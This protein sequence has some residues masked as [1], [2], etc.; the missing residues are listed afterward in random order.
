MYFSD[1]FHQQNS[2]STTEIPSET[3]IALLRIMASDKYEKIWLIKGQ[4]KKIF[5][6]LTSQGCNIPG[7]N[8][9]EKI[10][11]LCQKWR[12][13]KKLALKHHHNK[14]RRK[15]TPRPIH[16]NL[17][18]HIITKELKEKGENCDTDAN[19]EFVGNNSG[20]QDQKQLDHDYVG[21][22]EEPTNPPQV[23]KSSHSTNEES[24]PPLLVAQDENSVV[25]D[26]VDSNDEHFI[27]PEIV[28]IES[29]MESSGS[30]TKDVFQP[31][32]LKSDDR[33]E[34]VCETN[35]KEN[36]TQL[37][38]IPDENAGKSIISKENISQPVGSNSDNSTENNG[39]DEK[40]GDVGECDD[41]NNEDSMDSDS[42]D[43]ESATEILRQ[44]KSLQETAMV[45][46]QENF[47]K[48]I[49]LMEEQVKNQ[50]TLNEMFFHYVTRRSNKAKSHIVVK[51]RLNK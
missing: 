12:N 7:L 51:E 24:S 21:L 35:T 20:L 29:F 33:S 44:I 42:C 13:L 47:A 2:K 28:S 34:N 38:H 9:E 30:K 39:N 15:S 36:E 17:I 40:T 4:W 16:Y 48:V 10:R 23:G 11:K 19:T 37:Q 22:S 14:T 49:S 27:L 5:E 41:I 46:Q 1:A 43:S 31:D 32:N 3:T 18:M 26:Y 6:E 45:K 50:R 25:V 8:A